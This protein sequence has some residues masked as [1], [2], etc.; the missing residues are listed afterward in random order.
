MDTP[1]KAATRHDMTFHSDE[2]NC[3][4][5]FYVPGGC[6]PRSGCIIMAHG[7]GG[8]RDAGLEPFA[9]CFAAAGYCVFFV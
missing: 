7:L 6:L 8:T 2:N 9:R 5:W 3:A 4:A 1:V